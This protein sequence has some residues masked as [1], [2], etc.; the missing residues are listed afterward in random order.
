MKYPT[1][2]HTILHILHTILHTV[3]TILHTYTMP[4]Q[5]AQ[6]QHADRSAPSSLPSGQL[7]AEVIVSVVE[8]LD[9]ITDRR[10]L[11][12]LLRVSHSV[13]DMA[14]RHM[15]RSVTL[16][17]VQLSRIVNKLSKRQR[18]CLGFVYRLALS[19]PPKDSILAKVYDA[20]G[21]SGIPLFPNV[22]RLILDDPFS[23]GR[24][25]RQHGLGPHFRR[26]A[27]Q[28]VLLFDTPEVCIR[29]A[30]WS[31]DRLEYLPCRSIS[32]S[33]LTV[34]SGELNWAWESALPRPYRSLTFYWATARYENEW[35]IGYIAR[36]DNDA[37]HWAID[38]PIVIYANTGTS[39]K[40]GSVERQVTR[41]LARNRGRIGLEDKGQVRIVFQ[42]NPPP[43]KVC[44]EFGWR[45][46]RD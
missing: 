34:H 19:P 6:H 38:L 2:L 11:L 21:T 44:S 1:I 18:M 20:A 29:G 7:P 35:Q 26:L 31:Q 5:T 39:N 37:S 16:S 25:D 46:D 40:E 23:L 24:V 32:S 17:D 12:S 15:Y 28:G 36:F 4:R 22:R 43:C 30:T 27:E 3:H 10:T 41:R 9:P 13:W 33:N 42:A 14:A 8:E 45:S